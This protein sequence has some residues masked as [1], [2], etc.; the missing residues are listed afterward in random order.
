M[1][2]YARMNVRVDARADIKIA[3]RLGEPEK[4]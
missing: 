3:G 1:L 4:K 2:K